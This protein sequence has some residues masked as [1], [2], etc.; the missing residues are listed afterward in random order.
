MPEYKPED[1]VFEM[2]EEKIPVYIP[3][4]QAGSDGDSDGEGVEPENGVDGEHDSDNE[5]QVT[6]SLHG[7]CLLKPCRTSCHAYTLRGG[8]Q[9][10][11]DIAWT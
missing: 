5:Q 3:P 8:S 6:I 9:Q 11:N 7:W 2:E 10:C 1:M 4:K